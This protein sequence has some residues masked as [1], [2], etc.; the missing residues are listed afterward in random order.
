[1]WT[2]GDDI[3]DGLAARLARPEVVRMCNVLIMRPRDIHVA[4]AE[5]IE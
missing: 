1:M 3:D 5:M 4:R 2:Q